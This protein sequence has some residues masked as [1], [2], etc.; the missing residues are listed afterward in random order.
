MKTELLHIFIV[1]NLAVQCEPVNITISPF[2]AC[3]QGLQ[4]CNKQKVS[5]WDMIEGNKNLT[6]ISLAWFGAVRLERKPL[7]YEDEQRLVFYKRV[8]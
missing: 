6:P 1:L 2:C 8:H 7:T 5:P 4:I 3:D